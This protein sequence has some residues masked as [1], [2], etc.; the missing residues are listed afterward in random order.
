GTLGGNGT[1]GNTTIAGGMLAPGN[2]IGT[3][4]V[5]GN[6]VFGAGSV[7][8][9][10]GSPAAADRTDVSGTADL[11]GGTVEVTLLPGTFLTQS[12]TILNAAGG[13]G[14]PPF[15]G[16]D[17]ALLPGLTT[18]LDYDAN[19]AYVVIVSDRGFGA[20]NLNEQAV[21]GALLDYFD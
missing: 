8:A 18:S 11:S 2:S 5:A 12:R 3:L 20:L 14:G 4:H 10:E 21:A 13:L 1:V 9:V 15:A 17:A 19:N 16:L 7:Y 6:L